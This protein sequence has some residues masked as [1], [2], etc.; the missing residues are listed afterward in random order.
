MK[1]KRVVPILLAIVMANLLAAAYVPL[2]AL[3]STV[4]SQIQTATMVPPTPTPIQ[5]AT[6]SLDF[7]VSDLETRCEDMTLLLETQS[8]AFDAAMRRAESNINLLLAI[9]AVASVVA[10]LAGLL[11]ARVWIRSLVEERV[12]AATAEEVSRL[13]QEELDRLKK[14]WEPKFAQLYA[15]YNRLCSRGQ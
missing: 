8:S 1:A 2:S 3:A 10:A 13:A 15:D 11:V 4:R 9:L 14:E 7:R 6:P 5:T 12:K